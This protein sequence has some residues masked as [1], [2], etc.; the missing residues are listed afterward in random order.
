MYGAIEVLYSKSEDSSFN[1]QADNLTPLQLWQKQRLQAVL[2]HCKQ[3]CPEWDSLDEWGFGLVHYLVALRAVD[4]LQTHISSHSEAFSLPSSNGRLP[5]TILSEKSSVCLCTDG[6]GELCDW[7]K[8]G[9]EVAAALESGHQPSRGELKVQNMSRKP[10]IDIALQESPNVSISV[11]FIRGL[12]S[13]RKLAVQS[14]LAC[15]SVARGSQQVGHE[16]VEE[17][18]S[19]TM[20]G[21]GCGLQP[22]V[23]ISGLS[24]EKHCMVT[25]KTEPEVVEL[26]TQLRS[27]S[28]LVFA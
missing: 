15:E 1:A 13:E 18:E 17:K 19:L 27:V 5:A 16:A 2:Q 14:E 6:D 11:L 21:T 7:Q 8:L 10:E 20:T 9:I 22:T 23:P 3:H 12:L 24:D 25:S 26:E 28:R 4:T